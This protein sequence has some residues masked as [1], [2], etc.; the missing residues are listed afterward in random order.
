MLLKVFAVRDTKVEAYLPPFTMRSKG[1]AI[2]GFADAVIDKSGA[3][4]KYPSDF[5]LFYLGEFDDQTASF[6]FELAPVS[7]GVGTD[8]FKSDSVG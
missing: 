2:R 5:V 8:F 4:G 7:L 1:E 3:I 6:A